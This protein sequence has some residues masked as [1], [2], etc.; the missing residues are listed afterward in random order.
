MKKHLLSLVAAAVVFAV[1]TPLAATMSAAEVTCR[2]PFSF[3]VAG[4]TMAPG[5][6]S[7]EARD[8]LLIVRGAGSNVVVMTN[9]TNSYGK[10]GVK[11]VFLKTGERYDLAEVWMAEGH[12]RDIISAPAR[13]FLEGR[14]QAANVPVERI[15]IAAN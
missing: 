10:T 2:I 14:A 8:S 9:G 6:Y 1:L 13:R 11:L 4:R 12:G 5:S 3:I 7:L 15:V